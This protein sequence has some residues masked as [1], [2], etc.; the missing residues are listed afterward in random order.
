MSESTTRPRPAS[1]EAQLR[2]M[3]NGTD[4]ANRPTGLL[5]LGCVVAVGFGLYAL[6]AFRG[7]SASRSS[8]AMARADEATI[9]R[10]IAEHATEKARTPD[11]AALF[12]VLATMGSDIEK[13]ARRTWGVAEGQPVPGVTVGR[14]IDGQ[15]FSTQVANILKLKSVEAN[16]ADQPLDKVL[17]WL[18]AVESDRFL[19]PTFVSSLTLSPA[20]QGWQGTVRFSTYERKTP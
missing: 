2:A 3:A 11:I 4:R 5:V 12:P 8:L 17:A 6:A 1:V 20:G 19:G 7:W 14:A 13:A 16:I 10:L 15:I 9:E 18:A